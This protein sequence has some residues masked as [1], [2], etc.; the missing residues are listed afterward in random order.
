MNIVELPITRNGFA[1]LLADYGFK[2]GVE[3]GTDE[4]IYAEQLCIANPELKLYCIDPWKSY[5]G[6]DDIRD[7]LVLENNYMTTVKRLKHYN[8]EIIRKFSAEALYDFKEGTI[9]F[10]YIDG[11]H[12]FDYVVEDLENWSKIV[13]KGGIISGH[14][15]KYKGNKYGYQSVTDAIS[16]YFTDYPVNTLYLTTRMHQSTYFFINE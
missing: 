4:G 7:D 9:D 1:H 2:V 15:Y 3:I 8:C 13:K 10:V 14:D 6:Y 5:K 16:R 12:E 11:N